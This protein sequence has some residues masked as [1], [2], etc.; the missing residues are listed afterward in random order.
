MSFY[1]ISEFIKDHYPE[2]WG[3]VEYDADECAIIHRVKDE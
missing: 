1:S 2:Y 3:Y